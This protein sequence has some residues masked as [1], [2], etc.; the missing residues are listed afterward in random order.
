MKNKSLSTDKLVIGEM[1][2]ADIFIDQQIMSWST[3]SNFHSFFISKCNKR[4]TLKETKGPQ[5]SCLQGYKD[6]RQPKYSLSHSFTLTKL[7]TNVFTSNTSN[8]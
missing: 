4:K 7:Q 3:E 8:K 5:L 2:N 1:L 6:A